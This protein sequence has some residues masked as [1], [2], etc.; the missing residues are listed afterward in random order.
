MPQRLLRAAGSLPWHVT[1]A[2]LGIVNS[3]RLTA[4]ELYQFHLQKGVVGGFIRGGYYSSSEFDHALAWQK[5]FYN[6]DA[7]TTHKDRY[8]GVRAIRAF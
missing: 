3:R 2:P 1:C 7:T 6:N 4:D 8:D 5:Y